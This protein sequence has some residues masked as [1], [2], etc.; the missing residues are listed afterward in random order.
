MK[1]E[2]DTV[3]FESTGKRKYANNGI[4]GLSPFS[5]AVCEGY[6]GYVAYSKIDLTKE[7]TQELAQFMIGTWITW[8]EK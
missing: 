1:I 4:I 2:G 5:D 7:E 6:G 3:T 8:L